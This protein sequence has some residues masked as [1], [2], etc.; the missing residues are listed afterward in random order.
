MT[1]RARMVAIALVA[2]A[3]A[4][5]ERLEAADAAG[6]VIVVRVENR[7]PVGAADVQNAQS[8]AARFY[9][10]IGVSL[11]W[12]G[13]SDQLPST[14]R[15]VFELQVTLLSG[16]RTDRLLKGKSIS[17]TALG[18]A[19]HDTG[20]VYLFCERI[21]IAA[22]HERTPIDRLLGRVLAHELGHQLLPHQGHSLA[23]IMKA[24]VATGALTGGFTGP[25][26]AAIHALL[27]RPTGAR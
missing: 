26:R 27:A 13:P 3:G 24:R 14:L 10:E 21:E 15:P 12:L 16:E 25:Q 6:R 18:V 2:M 4:A 17:S 8:I 11:V 20:R 19:P 5:P 22:A 7:S 23:G 1:N 9:V